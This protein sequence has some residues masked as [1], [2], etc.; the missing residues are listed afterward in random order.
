MANMDDSEIPLTDVLIEPSGR[1]AVRHSAIRREDVDGREIIDALAGRASVLGFADPYVAEAIRQ[2]ANGYLGDASALDCDGH[3]L[4]PLAEKIRSM[5]SSETEGVSA[6]AESVWI[7][8]S[9]ED[10]MEAMIG[11]SRARGGGARYRTLSLVG[12]DHGRTAMCRSASGR[13]E[14]HADFG[15]MLAGFDH[16]AANDIASLRSAV[17]ESTAAVLLSP[18][19]LCDAA[20]PRDH[21]YLAAVRQLCDEHDLLLLIDESRLCIG[22]SGRL[23]TYTSISDIVADAVVVSGGLF[24]GLP[25]GLLLAGPRWTDSPVANT[26]LYPLQT[27]VATATL[28]RVAELGWLEAS[29]E[30][31]SAFPVAVAETIA[32]FEFIRDLHATGTTVG[33]ETDL[34]A[35][36]LVQAAAS[37]GLRIEAAG[38]TSI[39][40]QLPLGMDADDREEL[41]AR[42]TRTMSAMELITEN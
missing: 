25:G 1:S 7:Y 40:M 4:A 12:S 23:L 42:L 31:T 30:D 39:K 41:L 3:D 8:P 9:A 34:A 38:E 26:R 21:D 14:L 33:I 17:D 37:V 24:G 6:M 22:S 2:V 11:G 18:L 13:P 28:E 29:G 10:A 27:A 16:V 5:L 19:D 20:R 32:G 36:D 15:P 35:I